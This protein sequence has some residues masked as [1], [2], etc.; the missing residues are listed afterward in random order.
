MLDPIVSDKSRMV[1]IPVLK[2]GIGEGASKHL[3]VPDIPDELRPSRVRPLTPSVRTGE[4]GS[5]VDLYA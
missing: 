3:P 5:L 1:P 4:K 2:A